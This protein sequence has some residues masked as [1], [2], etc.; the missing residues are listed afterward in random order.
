MRLP[1][2]SKEQMIG[3]GVLAVR[4]VLGCMFIMS[5]VPKIQRPYDFLSSIYGYEIVGPKMGVLVAVALPW[6]ELFA[7]ICLLGGV[8]LGAALLASI[9]MGALFTFV[10]AS[11]LWRHLDI[12]CGCFSA[13]AGKISYLTLIRA[14]A[15]TLF[16]AVAYGGTVLLQ[17]KR[18]QPVATDPEPHC[19][20]D[21]GAVPACT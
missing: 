8:L 10:L 2:P 17:P 5:S 16:S 3:T 12:S 4:L 15:I 7:G 11:A 21:A 18:W 9:A 20:P 14:V 19:R 1:R 6:V 13:A